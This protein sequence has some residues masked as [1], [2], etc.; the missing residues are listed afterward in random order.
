MNTFGAK[1]GSM[2]KNKS[3]DPAK[4]LELIA[5]IGGLKDKIK[6]LNA[7]KTK[8]DIVKQTAYLLEII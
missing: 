2:Q 6:R 1:Q 7:L 8:N 5:A 3:A 4:S